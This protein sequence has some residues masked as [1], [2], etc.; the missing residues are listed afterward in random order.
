LVIR[1]KKLVDWNPNQAITQ[2]DSDNRDL[3]F[4]LFKQ[5]NHLVFLLFSM[6][7]SRHIESLYWL[8]L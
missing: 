1:G 3:A 5:R 6:Q 8:H 7:T 2:P 4:P